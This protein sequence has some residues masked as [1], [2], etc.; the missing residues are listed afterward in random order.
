MIMSN[1]VTLLV[2]LEP[3]SK[4]V[5]IE[6]FARVG[7]QDETPST[8]GIGHMLAG[9]ILSG[10][11][12]R[13]PLKLSRLVSEVGGNFRALWQW[14]YIEVYAVTVPS[15][16][17][18]TLGLLADSVQESTLD[19]RAI[20]YS[21]TSLIRQI[22]QQDDDT[23]NFA[24]TALRR[25]I[26][27][28]TPYDRAYL[29]EL[30][31]IKNITQQNLKD[32]YAKN[33]TSDRI[34]IS[35]AGNV[36]PMEVQR[37]VDVRFGNMKRSRSAEIPQKR[38]EG[39]YGE[40]LINKP[41]AE[42]YIMVGYPAAGVDDPDYSAMCVA[43][44]IL[45][46]NKSSLLFSKLR[47]GLGLGYQV[48]SLFPALKGGSHIAAYLGMDSSRA[49]KDVVDT[50]K[51]T[52]EQQF[53]VLRTGSF[54]DDDLVRAK[55]YLIGSHALKHERTK[56]R[57]FNLGWHE[58]IGLG[59]QYDFL[60]GDKINAV[61]REDVTRVCVKYFTKPSFVVLQGTSGGAETGK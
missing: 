49:T 43:N 55:R 18:D 38:Y 50:V 51:K 11:E 58:A 15:V 42:V 25:L 33:F 12:G 21:R 3:E 2:H 13:A 28:K 35:V 8:T 61:T 6:I 45:G 31:A 23:F 60:Y 5:A 4:V 40:M 56:D 10:T 47:E 44:V 36:D 41:G 59:Y 7:A 54:T 17:S 39:S 24:Y 19:Q 34:V 14:N 1:G 27:Y 30:S 52:M 16:W 57:A 32:F 48:G 29:G 20:D 9:S 46:G 26:H 37:R 22:S 53:D